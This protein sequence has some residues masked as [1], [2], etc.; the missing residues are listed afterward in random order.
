MLVLLAENTNSRK[1]VITLE[2]AFK[3]VGLHEVPT[4]EKTGRPITL[5]TTLEMWET[6][7]NAHRSKNLSILSTPNSQCGW[8]A[9]GITE[10]KTGEDI[11]ITPTMAAQPGTDLI[12]L[13]DFI[14]HQ[15][16]S[17]QSLLS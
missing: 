3:N 17:K 9:P 7:P 6:N 13:A 4:G 12:G 14:K 5:K 8:L 11:F 2:K 1:E 16:L 15:S 10:P